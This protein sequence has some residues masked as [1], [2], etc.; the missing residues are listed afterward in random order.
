[1]VSD[2]TPMQRRAAAELIA[3]PF[4]FRSRRVVAPSV[5]DR[6]DETTTMRIPSIGATVP[7]LERIPRVGTWEIIGHNGCAGNGRL[8]ALTRDEPAPLCPA[9]NAEVRWQ[10]TH[11]APTVASDHLGAGHLP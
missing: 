9:C 1:M 7:S 3:A 4:G 5:T 6:I 10:L 11:V 8:K 2:G